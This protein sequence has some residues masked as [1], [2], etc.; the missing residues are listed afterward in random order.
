MWAPLALV[1]AK[2]IMLVKPHTFRNFFSIILFFLLQMICFYCPTLSLACT[3][4][5]HSR[6]IVI[7]KIY[8]KKSSFMRK[9]TICWL[10][11]F[12]LTYTH[13]HTRQLAYR[14]VFCEIFF[15]PFLTRNNFCVVLII[16]TNIRRNRICKIYFLNLKTWEMCSQH[17]SRF[18]RHNTSYIHTMK[19]TYGL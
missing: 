11:F 19:K 2:P 18:N 15:S 10:F 6:K 4:L 12:F 1:A 13:T 9:R 5:S 8:K 3:F 7:K 14:L 16:F 17:T